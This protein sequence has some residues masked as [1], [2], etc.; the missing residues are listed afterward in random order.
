MARD[1]RQSIPKGENPSRYPSAKVNP[2]IFPSKK[3]CSPAELPI[4]WEQYGALM[5]CA[6]G[7]T[8]VLDL[9]RSRTRL[10][11]DADD[12]HQDGEHNNQGDHCRSNHGVDLGADFVDACRNRIKLSGRRDG[13]I[14][15]PCGKGCESH[16]AEGQETTAKL[17]N[18]TI[19]TVPKNLESRHIL[20]Q[21]FRDEQRDATDDTHKQETLPGVDT[22]V[23]ASLV[24]YE[25]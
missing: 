4:V 13:G 17:G 8:K 11:R 6:G 23:I 10:L 19:T 5:P 9:L 24:D 2:A 14:L 21:S 20:P 22:R 3:I 15:R 7:R 1:T 18:G 25:G 16:Q 12:K